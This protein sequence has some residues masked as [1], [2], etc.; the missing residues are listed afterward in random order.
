MKMRETYRN[1]TMTAG[2]WPMFTWCSVGAINY[3]EK[4]WRRHSFGCRMKKKRGEL[5]V[6]ERDANNPL[7]GQI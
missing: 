6:R 7:R 2:V 3:D 5:L 4:H 1:S